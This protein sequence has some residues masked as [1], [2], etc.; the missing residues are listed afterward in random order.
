MTG[1][2]VECAIVVKKEVIRVVRPALT[3]F[4]SYKF[5]V[6]PFDGTL[7]GFDQ[8]GPVMEAQWVP[9]AQRLVLTMRRD[10]KPDGTYGKT[11]NLDWVDDLVIAN[12]E[13]VPLP[14]WVENLRRTNSGFDVRASAQLLQRLHM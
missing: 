14:A 11:E 6:K 13:D 5:K 2:F 1:D 4:I 3:H 7:I 12:V 10:L 8:D 9:K